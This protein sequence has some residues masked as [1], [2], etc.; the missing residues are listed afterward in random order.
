MKPKKRKTNGKLKPVVI[1]VFLLAVAVILT[2][3]ANHKKK[4]TA[5]KIN[6]IIDNE[7]VTDNLKSEVFLDEN[8]NVYMSFNDIGNY[9]DENI[10]YDNKYLRIITSSRT[11]IASLKINEN[12]MYVNGSNVKIYGA[13]IEKNGQIYL[14]FSAIKDVYNV[15]VNYIEE[16]KI[17][18]IDSLEKEQKKGNAKKDSEIKYKPTAFSETVD[19]VKKGDSL[20]IIK[21]N[22]ENGWTKVRTKRGK[23]GFIKDVTNIYIQRE[24]LEIKNQINGKVNIIHEFSDNA[25]QN[26]DETASDVINVFS[27]LVADLD[28]KEENYVK[29][30]IDQN[31]LNYINLAHEQNYKVWG[32]VSN[33]NYKDALSEII[34]DYEKRT[35]VIDKILKMVIEYKLDGININFENVS[36]NDEEAFSRFVIELA[37]RLKE[38]GK[39][40]VVSLKGKNVGE[41][42]FEMSK[43]DKIIDY[44]INME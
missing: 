2:L 15:E 33:T 34:S 24:Q 13:A 39:A 8:E 22:E 6:V 40:M 3:A 44:V 31:E 11:K 18:T 43:I 1:A 21:E 14:P 42:N 41:N 32:C 4:D 16:T 27:I 36:K 19:N 29:V 10:F 25:E 20:F 5:K 7:N 38:Y 17:L 9:F 28:K 35:K 23:I 37:P 12:Q 30:K 26:N